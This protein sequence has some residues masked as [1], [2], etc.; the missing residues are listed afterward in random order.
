MNFFWE[1]RMQPVLDLDKEYGLV[2]EGGG[3]KG[4]YQIGAWIALREA[5]VKIKGVAGTSVGA[6]NGAL[7]C[8][9]DEEKAKN[10]WKTISYSKVMDVDDEQMAR[11][12]EKERDPEVIMDTLRDSFRILADGGTDITPLRNLLEEN[13]DEEKIRNG[14]I[15]FFACTYSVTD[16][17]EWEVDMRALPEGQMKDML[18][19]SSY[20]P[21]FKNV[22]LQGKTFTDGGLTNVLPVDTLVNRGYEDVILLR[23]FG[24]GHM[25]RFEIPENVRVYEISP[26]VSLGS[27]LQFDAAKSKRN[28]G[29]GYYDA[30]RLIYGLKGH[31]YYIEESEEECYYLE[32]FLS[33]NEQI[34]SRVLEHYRRLDDKE[35]RRRI[36]LEEVLPKIADELKLPRKWSYEE[37]YL[38]ILEA[39]ARIVKV[40]KYEIYTPKTLLAETKKRAKM[41]WPAGPDEDA[42][43]PGFSYLI[44]EEK[45]D[46]QASE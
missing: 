28:M 42:G 30:L 34:L 25:K 8:M 9:D 6:L 39:T 46:A 2:L 29:I 19:A 43:L 1:E 16:R 7:I 23:I 5:G 37:L 3:A 15:E 40:P 33:V 31:I 4:A 20:L 13:I 21:V 45:S 32:R 36:F 24:M 11:L 35:R 26:R 17:K 22:K 27:M 44:I 38:A 14:S 41:L 12:F 18:L 10:L